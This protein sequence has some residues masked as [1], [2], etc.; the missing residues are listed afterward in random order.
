MSEQARLAV[1]V[2]AAGSMGT[3]IAERLTAAGLTVLAVGRGEDALAALARRVP[4]VSSCVADVEKDAAIDAIRRAVDQP[5]RMV[6]HAAGLPASAMGSLL[7]V[8]TAG[9]AQSFEI[10][11][12]GMIRLVRAVD[13]HL[14]PGSRLVAIAGHYGLE[15]GAHAANPGV[16]NAA[17][18]NLMRQYSLLYGK[19]GV[20]AHVVA[21]GPTTTDRFERS[22][23]RRAASRGVTVETVRDEIKAESPLNAIATSE[24]VAW[25]VSLLLAPE[26]DAITGSTLTLDNGRRRGLP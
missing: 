4:G 26:A 9:V 6:V 16:A 13:Q 5:V 21:P 18:I 23:A 22:T 11:V 3:V 2:G 19:R 25:A 17:L 1:V 20:T 7:E 24:Q 10:K 8:S 15:P 12:G 14:A